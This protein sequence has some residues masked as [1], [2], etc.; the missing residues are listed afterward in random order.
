MKKIYKFI[1]ISSVTF[2]IIYFSLYLIA[3]F[4]PKLPIRNTNSYHFYDINGNLY[5]NDN[6]KWVKLDEISRDLINATIAVEDKNFYNHIGFDYLRILKALYKNVTSNKT[7][8]G[9]S[10]ITQQYAKNLYLNFD[11]T[12][13]RKINE[14][15][16][17]VRLEVQYSKDEILEGYLNT[18]NYGGIFGIE[19]ASEYYFGKSSK[20]LNLAESS[21]LAGIPKSPNNY[22]PTINIE[23]A[24]KRQKTVLQAMLNNNYITKEQYDDAINTNLKY[25]GSLDNNSSNTIMY[26]QQAVI[27]ELES[28]KEI[29]DSFLATGG[30]KIYTNLDM[31]AQNTLENSINKY[32]KE[33]SPQIAGIMVNP[34]NSSI[35]ALIGG[36]NY[37]ESQFNRA[38]NSKRAV[39]STIKP[40]L[41]Y[42]ALENGFTP[43]TTFTSEKTTFTFS[44]GELY[45]PN[46]FNDKYPNKSISLVSAIAYS[47]NVYAVKTH[48]FLGEKNLVDIASRVG[49]KEKLDP[50]PS[51]ALGSIGMSLKDLINGYA[52][53]ASGGLKEDLH[54][55]NKVEDINGKVL[56]QVR[57]KK[58]LVLNPSLVY[59]LNEMLTSTYNTAFVDYSYPTCYPIASKL[60]KKYAIK[61]G[62][63]DVDNLVIGYDNNIL[64]GLWSGYDN[65]ESVPADNSYNLKQVWADTISNYDIENKKEWYDI[66]N[67]VI[68][69]I[70][71]PIDGTLAN[72]KSKKKTIMYYINGTEPN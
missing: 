42:S 71:N 64:L 32:Y 48:L 20:E 14:A 16:L 26:Y 23:N 50:I 65:N 55:I 63:T 38:I 39:G 22:S 2:S 35:I 60:T 47:D 7:L 17:T 49:I 44:D 54:L 52:T 10:T 15:W 67:N 56:Y 25:I 8:E 19:N 46:N 6:D 69:V 34:N 3:F 59:I 27:N 13:K 21:M 24:K 41:Y 33:D 68:G 18:I 70:I 37:K 51:L 12:L 4:T 29:P 57:E 43:S 1:L 66:P 62:T 31:N 28:I 30:L 5:P 45:S 40:F 36:K 58:E 61:S 11:K 72:N 53:L 9:A